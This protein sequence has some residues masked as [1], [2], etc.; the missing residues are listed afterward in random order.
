MGGLF[1]V[2]ELTCH[3]GPPQEIE[4]RQSSPIAQETQ[5]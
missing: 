4:T 5:E 2:F 3:P 1:G